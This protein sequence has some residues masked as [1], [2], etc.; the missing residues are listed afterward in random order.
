M[1][2]VVWLVDEF[3]GRDADVMLM[4]RLHHV[5]TMQMPCGRDVHAIPSALTNKPLNITHP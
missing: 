1:V 5:D 4:S 3:C 2:D